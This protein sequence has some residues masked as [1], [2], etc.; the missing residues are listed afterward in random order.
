MCLVSLGRVLLVF[1]AAVLAVAAP[2]GAQAA[3]DPAKVLRVAS[4][5]IEA[6]DP[7]Q[8]D[9][10]PS[11]QVTTAIFEG[12]YQYGYLAAPTRLLPSTLIRSRVTASREG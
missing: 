2:E 12:L 3:A 1:G 9:D 11:Y 6:L 4:P 10:D 5:D 7:Q 8:Y